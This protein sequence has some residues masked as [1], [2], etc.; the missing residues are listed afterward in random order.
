MK[1]LFAGGGTGGHVLPIVAIVREIRKFSPKE[2]FE[3]F[4]I[5]PRDDFGELLLSHEDIE[6]KN[7][8]AGKIRRYIDRENVL[9]NIIDVLFKI[10]IGILQSFFHIFIMSPDLIL[11][12]GGFGSIPTVIAGWILRVPIFLHESD[13]MPGIANRFVAKFA[14]QIFVSFEKTPYFLEDKMILTGNPIR[15]ELLDGSKEEAKKIFDLTEKKPL[16]LI[17]GGSQGAQRINDRILEILPR[18]LEEFELIHQCGENNFEQIKAE[19]KVMMTKYLKKYYHLS[20]FLKE[21]E[22]KAAYAAC[23]IVVSRSGAGSIFEI[24]ALGKPSI[25]IPLPES[26]QNH[27]FMNAYKYAEN[28]AALILEEENFTPNFFLTQ[29]RNL[30]SDPGKLEK[31]KIYAKQFAKPKAAKTIAKYMLDYLTK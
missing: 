5:G 25:L 20:P 26:A 11:S 8:L 31:M 12:K 14:L 1:I 16:I 7:V 24:S 17:L 23:D 9:K 19:A 4:Y 29:L 15:R 28:G 27:Q 18:L 2:K 21:Q 10:P 13:A 30:F 6:I 3:F 22:I